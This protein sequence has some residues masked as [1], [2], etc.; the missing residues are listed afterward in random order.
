MINISNAFDNT[1]IEILSR[2]CKEVLR[3]DVPI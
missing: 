2:C 3:N 1:K